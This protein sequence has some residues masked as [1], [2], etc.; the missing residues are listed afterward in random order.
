MQRTY[1]CTNENCAKKEGSVFHLELPSEA[2]E[3]KNMAIL[4]CPRCGA[5][6]SMK[7]AGSEAH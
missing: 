6:L 1:I 3:E 5:E 7:Q 4:F 2:V